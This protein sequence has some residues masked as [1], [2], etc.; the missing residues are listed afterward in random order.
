MQNMLILPNLS[1]VC[2][3]GQVHGQMHGQHLLE[4]SGDEAGG[5]AMHARAAILVQLRM[6]RLIDVPGARC[7]LPV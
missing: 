7:P 1:S 4:Y 6:D 5:G 2:L 3:A